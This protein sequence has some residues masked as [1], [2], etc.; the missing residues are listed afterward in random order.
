MAPAEN[1]DGVVAITVPVAGERKVAPP[2]EVEL[3]VGESEVVAVAQ[4]DLPGAGPVDTDGVDAIAVPIAEQWQVPR[5]SEVERVDAA[6]GVAQ[7]PAPVIGVEKTNFVAQGG[8]L[9]DGRN[10]RQEPSEEE[11]A[12]QEDAK[13]H[14][15]TL[16]ANRNHF[17]WSSEVTTAYE[18][19]RTKR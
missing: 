12:D 18:R 2:P 3:L 9:P 10:S 15:G 17:S 16:T 13:F 19:P 7:I 6:V 5:V 1:A 14:G 4:Q 11:R 8:S